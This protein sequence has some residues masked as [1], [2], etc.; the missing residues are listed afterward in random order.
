M[1]EKRYNVK[2]QRRC[3][4]SIDERVYCRIPRTVRYFFQ[5]R[6]RYYPS[7]ERNTECLKTGLPLFRTDLTA[8]VDPADQAPPCLT[9]LRVWH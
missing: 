9:F 8:R 3:C 4:V 1:Q 2:I 7:E 5:S 6:L